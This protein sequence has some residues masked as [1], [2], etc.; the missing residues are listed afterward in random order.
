MLKLTPLKEITILLLI[1]ASLEISYIF[2]VYPKYQYMGFYLDISVSK[3]VLS[4]FL[5]IFL[6]YTLRSTEK[7]FSSILLKILLIVMII[8]TLSLYGLKGESTLFLLFFVFSFALTSLIVRLPLISIWS[9]NI[10]IRYIYMLLGFLILIVFVNLLVFNGLPSLTAINLF[11]VYDVRKSVNYGLPLMGYLVP[12]LGKVI[13]PFLIGMFL[14][15]KEI[16]WSIFFLF[17]QIL[18]YLYTGHKSFLFSPLIIISFIYFQRKGRVYLKLSTS[19]LLVII[20][21]LILAVYGMNTGATLFI[22]RTFFLTAQNYYY[23]FDFFSHNEFV[24]LSH[25]IFE[26]LYTYPYS[27][28]PPNLIG[29]AYYHNPEGWVNTGYLADA[30]MNFGFLGMIVFSLLF[31]FLLLIIDSIKTPLV[32]KV[33]A[34]LIPMYALRSGAFFT[35]LLTGGI[36]L[37]IVITYLYS[38]LEKKLLEKGDQE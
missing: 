29:E 38:I 27:L 20:I 32:L 31:G 13:N 35:S 25:S 14:Y 8:P 37:G 28:L 9:I 17:L 30:Y 18:L 11:D 34:L 22:R 15:K 7:N 1:K 2:Y 4:N 26:G 5:L 6:F 19:I 12:W 21:S 24:K 10:N 36:L 23:Y 33:A 3:W 16:R